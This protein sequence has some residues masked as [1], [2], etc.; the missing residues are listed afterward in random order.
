MKLSQFTGRLDA[1]ANSCTGYAEAAIS[2]IQNAAKKYTSKV[3]DDTRRAHE[4][5]ESYWRNRNKRNIGVIL[6]L[7]ITPAL[8][9]FEFL[10]RHFGWF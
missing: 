4:V 10:A 1:A 3:E 2:N 6:Y 7:A 8:V 5:N 9:A